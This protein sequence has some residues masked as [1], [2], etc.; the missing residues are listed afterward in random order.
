MLD[1]K[2]FFFYVYLVGLAVFTCYKNN[3]LYVFS[4][5]VSYYEHQF[6]CFFAVNRFFYI[7]LDDTEKC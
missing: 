2:E 3:D 6:I 5:L 7:Y 1:L 4:S